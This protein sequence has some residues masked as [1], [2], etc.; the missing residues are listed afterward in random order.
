MGIRVPAEERERAR[1]LAL[2]NL[3][4][5]RELEEQAA[6]T[7]ANNPSI[8]P[9]AASASTAQAAQNTQTA[10]AETRNTLQATNSHLPVIPSA[11]ADPT[12]TPPAQ[13]PTVAG[14]VTAP[15]PLP[16]G[17]PSP[18]GTNAQAASATARQ[19]G[20]GATGAS[21]P[22][23]A[24]TSQVGGL[25]LE[26]EPNAHNQYDRVSYW[27]K[28]SMI[29]DL[30]AEDPDLLNKFLRKEIR[31]IT[32]A[33]SGVTTGFN[34]GNV[35]ITDA[36]SSNFRNR[37]SLTTEIKMQ[38]FEPYSL[39]LPDRLFK[40][41]QDL[42]IRNWRL[43]PLMLQLEFRYI[44]QTGEIFSPTNSEKLVK[45]Y[46]IMIT[47]F[48]AQ[49]KETGTSYDVTAAVKGN[50]GFKDAY[51]IMPQS[52][53]INTEIPGSP[54]PTTPVTPVATPSTPAAPTTPTTP[55][56]IRLTPP[57]NS[58][59]AFFQQLGTTITD[60]YVKNRAGE[61]GNSVSSV[62]LPVMIYKFWTA[63][64]LAEQEIN[65]SPENNSRRASFRT[66]NTNSGEITVSRGI[67]VSSLV[68]DIL[69]SLKDPTFFY[70]SPQQGGM[71]KIP[72]IECVTKNVGWDLIR[73]DYVREF[74]FIIRMKE[75]NRPV[76]FQEFGEQ[77]QSSRENQQRRLEAIQKTL[78]KRYD[79]F[80]T[81]LNTE[82]LNC[83]IKFNQLHI[84]PT[85][86]LDVTPPVGYTD[87]SSVPV[88]SNILNPAQVGSELTQAQRQRNTAAQSLARLGTDR[89]V[90]EATLLQQLQTSQQEITSAEGRIRRI[91]RASVVPFD[92][93]PTAQAALE[94]VTNTGTE[95]ADIRSRITSI[96]NQNNAQAANRQFAEDIDI[97][98]EDNMLRLSYYAD[99]RD[100]V[101]LMTRPTN[102]GTPS[103]NN[104]P[105]EATRPMVSTILSQVY[106]RGGQHL[107]ELDLEI[108][109]DPYW[110]GL[111]DTERN[112][113]LL[114]WMNTQQGGVEPASPVRI[115]NRDSFVN[116]YDQ[117][118]NIMV[119]FRA[120]S[121]P[122]QNTGFQNL[123]DGS[124]FFYG[125]YTVIECV[126]EFKQGKFTQRLKAVR[127]LLINVSQLRAAERGSTSVNQ[128]RQVPVATPATPATTA[129]AAT[130]PNA[131]PTEIARSEQAAEQSRPAPAPAPVFAEIP[132]NVGPGRVIPTERP[133]YRTPETDRRG[134]FI[135]PPTGE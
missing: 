61:I 96:Q 87:S 121:P 5:Q 59:G 111:T 66:G 72:V 27:F 120:G 67:S 48:D 128:P 95:A 2:N 79:Y 51:T 70:T 94:L 122:D 110:L 9:Q 22:N 77:V 60:L 126:H 3:Q 49:L 102:V 83:D 19:P 93:E 56:G 21:A 58:V 86:L 24:N 91:G 76:P 63:P 47:D 10:A 45:V 38:I 32:V 116:R 133:G 109:G 37:S 34:L 43:A 85:P 20:A 106:D 118:A 7:V 119:K 90:D 105:S 84:I 39:T 74:N 89:S 134:R 50:L 29:N 30:D 103:G 53:R 17:S 97:Q 35:E 127:D 131:A 25:R 78:R 129:S 11:P 41:S 114:A 71:V 42:G 135:L 26:F 113:E 33:E 57:A 80:Y 52:H 104:D 108:R 115:V 69:A 23:T 62:Q 99:P 15:G 82:I 14:P 65:F 112:Q 4:R 1:Q 6:Q 55:A 16:T 36:I 28:L 92:N 12:T 73:N 81:G 125:V 117:D 101:N 98:L 124:T 44:K 64:G 18:T 31:Q 40:G 123:T 75:S 13:T 100:V 68:D 130:N 46:Q 88:N 107:L 54:P 8:D 132:N